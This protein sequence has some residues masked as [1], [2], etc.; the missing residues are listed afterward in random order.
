MKKIGFIIGIFIILAI[1]SVYIYFKNN[2]E[3][4]VLKEYNS[5]GQLIGT[6]EYI[7]RNYDTILNG[8]FIRYNDK[9]IKISEGRFSNNDVYGNCYYYND[10]GK[11]KDVHFRKNKKITLE[12]TFYDINENI[13]KYVMCDNLGRAIFLIKYENKI[14]SKYNGYAIWPLKLF[15]LIRKKQIPIKGDTLNVGDKIK[16]NFLIANIPYSNRKLKIETIGVDNS[17]IKRIV[18]YIKPNEVV[19]EEV[20]LNKGLNRIRTIVQYKFKDKETSIFNDTV[21]FDITVK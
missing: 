20:L 12:S 13:E 3:I 16:Y 4:K 11:L 2:S 15:K 18:N 5:K 9:G 6:N 8:K 1:Y 19:I 21:T 14:V 10:N 17:K 7:V